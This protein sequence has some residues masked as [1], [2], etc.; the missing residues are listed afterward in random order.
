M[1]QFPLKKKNWTTYFVYNT[2]MDYKMSGSL[3]NSVALLKIWIFGAQSSIDIISITGPNC[4]DVNN[5]CDLQM[6]Q[7]RDSFCTPWEVARGFYCTHCK[8]SNRYRQTTLS[9]VKLQGSGDTAERSNQIIP[10]CLSVFNSEITL[11]YNVS[12]DYCSGVGDCV[13]SRNDIACRCPYP[14]FGKNFSFQQ[15]VEVRQFA[16]IFILE[17]CFV[18]RVFVY[19]T[20]SRDPA[21]L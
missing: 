15:I 2:S 20:N 17:I 16:C 14:Y 21:F 1:K 19:P 11:R 13:Q 18:S 3:K 6:C 12:C 5:Y 10:H 7:S 8:N 4:W 9:T